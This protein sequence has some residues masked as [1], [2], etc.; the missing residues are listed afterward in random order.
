MNRR[1]CVRNLDEIMDS[2]K[3]DEMFGCVGEVTAVTVETREING[4]GYRVGL[5]EMATEQAAQDG[6]DRYHN[7]KRNGNTLVV[8]LD[9]PHVPILVPAKKTK[10][11]KEIVRSK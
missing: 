6:I 2:M 10:K 7:Q 4:R 11:A 5:V 9:K 3:L 1:L 8:T